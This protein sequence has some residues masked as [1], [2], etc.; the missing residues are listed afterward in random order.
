VSSVEDL[1]VVERL[2]EATV[3]SLNRPEVRNAIDKD[4]VRAL[5]EACG[6]LELDPRPAVFTG[7]GTVFAAGAD[8]REMRQRRAEDALRGMASGVF[9]R[10]AALPMPTVAAMNGPAIGGGAE[11]AYACDFRVATPTCRI[12]NPEVSLGIVPAAGACWRLRELVGLALARQV[13]LAGRV[14]GAD[15][16]LA[17]GLV[18]EVV[19]PDDLLPAAL[20][21]MA[22]VA[23]GAPMAVRLTKLALAAP[24]AAHPAFDNVAQAVAME[25]PEKA[26]RID[27]FLSRRARR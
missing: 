17:H 4:V 13:V 21:L 8:L 3:V 6:E 22:R 14:L 15:E 20:R 27:E 26:E 23:A 7:K 5:H 1:V 18:D 9:D 24:P 25:R 16:A 11:L 2:D 19:A 10:I 12:G